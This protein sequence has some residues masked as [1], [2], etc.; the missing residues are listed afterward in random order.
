MTD[1]VQVRSEGA[2]GYLVFNNPDKLNAISLEM[3]EAMGHGVERLA[4]DPA[5]R[6]IIVSGAGGKA[7]IAGADVSKYEEERM[8]DDAQEHY[9]RTGE[10][11][12]SALYDCDKV[13][14]A[15][16]DG[17]CIGGGISVAVSC[18]LR[19]ASA[20]SKFG[21]PAMRYG[22]GYRY[23]SLRRV[24]DLIGPGATKDLLL[25]GYM[26]DAP[27][28]YTK[29]LVGKVLPVEGFHGEVQ[30]IAEGIAAGAPLTAKQVKHAVAQ[31]VKD[32]EQREL[33]LSEQ[34]FLACYASADY[35]EGIRAFAEKRTPVFKGC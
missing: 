20:K 6:V 30:K 14:I 3:W 27:E 7:F 21:Q 23:K 25:G 28:A 15:A 5:V 31:I 32:P 10:K 1:K 9:A 26:F 18:D 12:L 24:A 8:G 13:T 19:I 2:I 17:Y 29:G 33:A 22:I 35:R 4:G 34:Y 16:I 11:A